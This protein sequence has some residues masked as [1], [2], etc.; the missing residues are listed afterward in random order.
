MLVTF[1]FPIADARVFVSHKNLRLPLPDWPEPKTNINPQFVHHFGVARERRN[2][3]DEAWADEVSFVLA[4]RGLRFEHLEKCYVGLSNQRFCPQCAFRRL[5]SDGVAVMRM[6]IGIAHRQR[7]PSLKNLTIQE[8]LTIARKIAQIPTLVPSVEGKTRPQPIFAQGKNLARLYAHASMN[9]GIT[10][11]FLGLK[12]VE[13]ANPLIIVELDPDEAN[14][15]VNAHQTDG[16]TL[17][18]QA[19]VNGAKVLF[20]RL[21]IE[22]GK[23][24]IWILQKGT[25]TLGQLRS[26]RI[27]LTRLHAEREVLDLILRQ[28]NRKYLLETQS[29]KDVNLLDQYFNERLKIVNRDHWGGIKQSEIVT[30][31]DATVSVVQPAKQDNLITKYNGGRR[32]ILEKI[33]KYQEQRLATRLVNVI[34]IENGGVMID[35]QVTVRGNGNIV[36]VAEYMTNVTNTVNNNISKSEVSEDI[37]NLL[38]ELNDEIGRIAKEVDPSD[39]ESFGK[40]LETLSK[41]VTRK[42]PQRRWFKFC[43]DGIKETAQ[44]V[45]EIAVPILNIISKLS[46]LLLA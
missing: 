28:I 13:A 20:C 9:R 46:P 18:D 38:K 24:P 31:F 21:E 16:L 10:D 6:E 29:E 14:L 23:V 30:A 19:Y 42:H 27:C 8:V 37:K 43:L 2:E 12:L 17:I 22:A 25:S 1:Q 41:E 11:K 5:F 4:R 45:G 40:N 35:K 26:L 7:Y 33:K 34:K 15:N 32:Q 36:N 39:V 3:P 44:T